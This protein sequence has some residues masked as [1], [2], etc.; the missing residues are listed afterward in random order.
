[1]MMNGIS[2][3]IGSHGFDK[4]AI[5]V[6]RFTFWEAR[7]LRNVEHVTSG[8]SDPYVRVLSGH[9]VRARTEVID[10]NL[11]PEWGESV[12]VPTRL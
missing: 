12:Y 10:N 8:K 1:M 11:N 2:D 7:D 3:A 5:A 9:Q 6:V 4:P